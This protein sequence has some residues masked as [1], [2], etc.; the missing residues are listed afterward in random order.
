[1]RHVFV[2]VTYQSECTQHAHIMSTKL[3]RENPFFDIPHLGIPL[4]DLRH[5]ANH[6][7]EPTGAKVF[8]TDGGPVTLR[9]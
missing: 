6:L 7:Q 8:G 4:G 3:E 9:F 2:Y 5:V 1:M